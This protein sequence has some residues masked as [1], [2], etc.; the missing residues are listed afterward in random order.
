MQMLDSSAEIQIE[1]NS[2][3]EGT[4]LY[5]EEMQTNFDLYR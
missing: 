2:E 4:I 1:E 5:P 3:S